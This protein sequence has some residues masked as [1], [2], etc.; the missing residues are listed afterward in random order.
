[1]DLFRFRVR[2]VLLNA[3]GHDGYLEAASAPNQT[4]VAARVPESGTGAAQQLRA[5]AG[6]PRSTGLD[7]CYA[8]VDAILD[9]LGVLLDSDVSA[10]CTE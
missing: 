5:E 2:W 6:V 3:N 9:G 1:M 4:E 7:A 8:R 10:V